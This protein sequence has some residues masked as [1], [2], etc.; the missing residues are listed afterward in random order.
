[1][2]K[3]YLD[4]DGVVCDF[5]KSMKQHIDKVTTPKKFHGL[6]LEHKIF[7]DLDFMPN[8]KKLLE[9]LFNDLKV[10]VEILSSLGSWTEHVAEESQRQKELWLNKHGI[11]C[12]RNFVNTWAEKRKWATP[13]SIMIDDRHDVID[14]FRTDGGYG[15]HYE[16]Q[17]WDT[18]EHT[19]RRTV[20]F[21]KLSQQSIML[22]ERYGISSGFGL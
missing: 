14:T 5:E 13:M 2:I 12:K 9:L 19:I 22:L 20:E 4:L 11:L 10:D 3:V 18:M 8:G 15:I 17:Y 7:E 21:L 16:D 6:V 1:M